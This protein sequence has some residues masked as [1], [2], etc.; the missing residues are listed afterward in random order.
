MRDSANLLPRE[1]SLLDLEVRT[2]IP[3]IDIGASI[4]A[5]RE[6]LTREL[7]IVHLGH[8]LAG[9]LCHGLITLV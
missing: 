1:A 4:P 5:T 6:C 7:R 3:F 9:A 2:G 8:R